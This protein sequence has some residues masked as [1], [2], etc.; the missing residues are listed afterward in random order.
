MDTYASIILSGPLK[1]TLPFQEWLQALK[2][3][4]LQA[5]TGAVGHLKIQ[6]VILM[7]Q[8]AFLSCKGQDLPALTA[9][10]EELYALQA[11]GTCLLTCA[12]GARHYGAQGQETLADGFELAG[13][14]EILKLIGE[15]NYQH[16]VLTG[17]SFTDI[18]QQYT[19]LCTRAP[20]AV[21]APALRLEVGFSFLR[22]N[23]AV[24][25][26]ERSGCGYVE[27]L[28]WSWE[29][30][31]NLLLSAA[32][33]EIAAYGYF[34][35]EQKSSIASTHN[36]LSVLSLC[37]KMRQLSL[38]EVPCTYSKAELSA[39]L[40]ALTEK[41]LQLTL[42]EKEENEKEASLLRLNF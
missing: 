6:H 19:A 4:A 27:E 29:Q 7:G 25:L 39:E 15:S 26:L 32:D 22:E 40:K 20:A 21:A 24:E 3:I 30:G 16:P 11:Q 31:L 35:S 2:D 37:K 34:F 23:L 14:M 41:E 12:Q 8:A 18:K 10:Q 1:G 9:L 42:Q 38:W 28:A 36:P 13:F 17:A 5:A 33:L